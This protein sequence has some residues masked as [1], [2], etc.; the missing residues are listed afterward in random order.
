MPIFCTPLFLYLYQTFQNSMDMAENQI[1]KYVWLVDTIHNAKRITFEEINNKWLNN[2]ISGGL[3]IPRR[4]FHKWVNVI[5]DLFNISI[6]NEGRGRYC[7]YIENDEEIK[8]GT[9]QS[10]LLNTISISNL[11]VNSQNISDRILL[12][13][14]PSS[15]QYLDG[16]LQAMRENRVVRFVYFNYWR[17]DYKERFIE[18]YCV[19]IFRQRW[20]MV[21]REV[22]SEQGDEKI[23]VFS[24]DRFKEF[25][26]TE[27]TFVYPD[28][29][30]PDLFF[31]DCFGVLVGVSQK[32]E[33]VLLKVTAGQANYWRDLPLMKN[34]VEKERTDEYSIFEVEVRP[35][36]DFKQE[37][38]WNAENVE[39]LQPQ[40]FRDEMANHVKRMWEM[41]R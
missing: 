33:K 31:Q 6:K 20:Y 18:P 10:W 32:A 3:E 30:Y 27:T 22:F 12:Q 36:F 37:V 28:D 15:R 8:K 23:L 39:V 24:I 4:T 13:D 19:K 35:T 5:E 14:I 26:I 7:Y 21:G 1:K 40:W 29:F 34:Q 16:I 38:L 17:G 11:I 9:L 41:Y 25:E 2:D